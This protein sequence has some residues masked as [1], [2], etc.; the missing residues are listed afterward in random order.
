[1]DSGG[2]SQDRNRD[3]GPD[4][5]PP[6]EP[7]RPRVE[8]APRG[9]TAGGFG[10]EAFKCARCGEIRHDFGTVEHDAVCTKCNTDMHACINCKHFDT[11]TQ[12]ECRERIPARIAKKDIRNECASF[13]AK[14]IRDLA[15]DKGTKAPNVDDA[16]KAFDAL[17]KK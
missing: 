12:W 14:I 8:G 13:A 5:R 1:M 7:L 6:L 15:A 2:G 9:R 10:P 3:R 11:S 16:R 4:N 17:F